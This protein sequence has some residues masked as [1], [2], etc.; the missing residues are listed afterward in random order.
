MGLKGELRRGLGNEDGG[1]FIEIE[2]KNVEKDKIG[3]RLGED[4]E[5]GNKGLKR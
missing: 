5:I 1:I 4:E 3:R 2:K